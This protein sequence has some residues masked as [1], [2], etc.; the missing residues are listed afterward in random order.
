MREDARRIMLDV[1]SSPCSLW[2]RGAWQGSAW[3]Q[4]DQSQG[5]KGG[6]W[7]HSPGPL[8][9]CWHCSLMA[10]RQRWTGSHHSSHHPATICFHGHKLH[11]HTSPLSII[12]SFVAW[13]LN[14]FFPDGGESRETDYAL[15]PGGGA[16]AGRLCLV[17]TREQWC[18]ASYQL[19]G[20]QETARWSPLMASAVNTW[21]ANSITHVAAKY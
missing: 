12:C 10:W 3:G 18:T 6:S 16:P 2:L 8:P 7:G 11:M 1:A 20:Q 5:D 9:L 15:C 4:G 21:L 13:H 19:D 14:H 17:V